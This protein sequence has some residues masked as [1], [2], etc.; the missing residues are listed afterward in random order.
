LALRRSI[1]AVGN[2][3]YRLM[4]FN[5]SEISGGFKINISLIIIIHTR[6]SS[7]EYRPIG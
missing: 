4:P 3:M 2:K 1:D 5:L 7:A 6:G